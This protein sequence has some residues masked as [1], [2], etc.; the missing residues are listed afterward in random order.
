MLH[1]Q[2]LLLSP[3]KHNTNFYN[4]NCVNC[5]TI[6]ALMRQWLVAK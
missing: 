1:M 3:E 2:A 5:S 4:L 6:E